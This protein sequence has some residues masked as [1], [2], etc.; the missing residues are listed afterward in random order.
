MQPTCVAASHLQARA[1]PTIGVLFW[2][3]PTPGLREPTDGG[4]H[5]LLLPGSEV[6]LLAGLLTRSP[7]RVFRPRR[8]L[9]FLATLYLL[10]PQTERQSPC[11][12]LFHS[13]GHG[14]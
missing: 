8:F 2:L 7:Q 14:S 4:W 3:T 9:L 5:N 1:P 12:N 11:G 6:P 13:P 10:R